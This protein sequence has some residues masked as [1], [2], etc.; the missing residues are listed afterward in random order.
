MEKGA[1]QEHMTKILYLEDD[2]IIG[3]V[4]KEYLKMA[5][6][7]TAWI[8]N[9]KE[10]LEKFKAEQNFDIVILDIMV[11]DIDGIQV[12]KEI[13]KIDKKVGI[14]ML[15]VLG[16]EKTQIETMDLLTDDYIIKPVPPVLLI[17]R[18]E[19]IMRRMRQSQGTPLQQMQQNSGSDSGNVTGNR[20]D[21]PTKKSLIMDTEGI[22][23][24]EGGKDV[25]LTITEYAILE[26][27]Y[28]HPQK[29]YTRDELLNIIYDQSYY[30]SDRVIDTH[31]KNMRKKLKGNYIRT[32]VGM[33][34]RW[35]DQ[36][37]KGGLDE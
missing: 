23:F 34:Y 15:S 11:P 18:I 31:I 13:R 4:T 35:N 12:L 19:A 24:L 5:G 30:G 10:A 17:K 16:D 29:V 3:A 6:Y 33:G 1:Y 20:C 26:I 2:E 8:C 25:G 9:G 22:R 14:L 27:L 7:D 28:K 32:V 37:G 36:E 21:T